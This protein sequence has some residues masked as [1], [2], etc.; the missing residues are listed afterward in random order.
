[1]NH[2]ELSKL[3]ELTVRKAIRVELQQ[4][5]K[6]I[7]SEINGK[8]KLLG[9]LS[10]IDNVEKK[11]FKTKPT[12]GIDILNEVSPFS[13]DEILIGTDSYNYRDSSGELINL[14][15]TDSGIAMTQVPDFIAEAMNRDYSHIFNVPKKQQQQQSNLKQ[16]IESVQ[17]Y[18]DEEDLSWLNEVG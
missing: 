10:D 13:K 9:P 7:I 18:E 1:M 4:L 3:I 5:K 11:K 17:P 15:T 6:E 8:N 14:P 12:F 16:V 2:R